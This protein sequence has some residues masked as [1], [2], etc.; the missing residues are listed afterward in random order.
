VRRAANRATLWQPI[1]EERDG[2]IEIDA[3]THTHT[4]TN[5]KRERERELQLRHL[6]FDK[7]HKYSIRCHNDLPIVTGGEALD[8]LEEGVDVPDAVDF[9]FHVSVL[10]GNGD[11]GLV[12][13]PQAHHLRKRLSR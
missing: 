12:K 11:D 8:F 3:Y 2:E 9:H 7:Y 13:F 4:H 10:T 5:T 1:T 6:L